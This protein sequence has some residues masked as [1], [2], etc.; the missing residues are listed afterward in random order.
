M[1][2]SKRICS[3]EGCGKPHEARGWCKRHYLRWKRHGNPNSGRTAKGAPLAWLRSVALVHD[4]DECLFWPFSRD[5]G[6]RGRLAINGKDLIASRLVCSM[7]HGDA[8][9]D[10]HQATH[11][12]GKGHL[13]CVNPKHL[14]WA[15][16]AEN[17]ADRVVHGTSNRGERCAAA[18]L[19]EADVLW[20]RKTKGT[21]L[22]REIASMLGVSQA[23]VSEA[24]N[25]KCWAWLD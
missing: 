17:Q 23:T 20:I 18:K 15:T 9:S 6:G 4:G 10:I 19:T 5:T 22:Q 1:A 13:G 21:L 14:R 8:P 2:D 25:G 24:M 16:N 12:C 3:I 7:S 11:S